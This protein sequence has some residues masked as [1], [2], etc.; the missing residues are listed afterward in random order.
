MGLPY[1]GLHHNAYFKWVLGWLD[2][3]DVEHITHAGDYTIS[4]LG[5]NIGKRAAMVTTP[6]LRQP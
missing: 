1:R 6:R 3:A 5:S 4:P 2:S